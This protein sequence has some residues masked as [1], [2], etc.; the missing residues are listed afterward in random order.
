MYQL[1][2]VDHSFKPSLSSLKEF[3][4][5]DDFRRLTQQ[6]AVSH[7]TNRPYQF[8]GQ[9]ITAKGKKRWVRVAGH[10]ELKDGVP[11]RR[12][13]MKQ[14]I[15]EERQALDE[16]KR[17]AERD[18]LTGLRNRSELMKRLSKVRHRGNAVALLLVDLD[19]FKD[20]NDTYGHE[21]GDVCLKEMAKRLSV[22][23]ARG[24]LIAR[25]G[26]DEFAVLVEGVEDRGVLAGVAR[27]ILEVA[28]SSVTFKDATLQFSG[29][30]GIAMRAN[31]EPFA[32]GDILGEADLA[33]YASKA[34]GRNRFSFFSPDMK[35]AADRKNRTVAAVSKA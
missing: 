3:Y 19:G 25:I 35:L 10:V 20:I 27:Q 6:V 7:E 15:T 5:I 28:S 17:L 2:E 30:I 16:I 4:P 33:L 12:Y 22:I 29:S 31:I 8:E 9:M 14:D 23:R 34:R 24:R 32:D 11:V 26:G 18:A 21:A 1:H 13:G